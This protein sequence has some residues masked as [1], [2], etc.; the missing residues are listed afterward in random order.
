MPLHPTAEKFIT[1]ARAAGARPMCG[2]TADEARRVSKQMFASA[3]PGEPVREG[4]GHHASR[5]RSGD[6]PARVYTPS[7]EGPFPILV[8]LHGGG[9][10][11]GD[12][13]S[14]GRRLP[15]DSQRRGCIVVSVD[16][17]LAPEH[18]FPAPAE[19]AYRATRWIAE[20]AASWE[21]TAGRSRSGGVSAGG[22]LAAVVALMARDRGGPAL[23]C[24]VLNGAGHRLRLR[25][26]VAY[27][28]TAR[29][30]VLTR[31]EM[32]YFWEHYL[33]SP[34]DGDHPYASPLRAPDL[35]GLPPA[36]RADGRV[37]PVAR[38]RPGLCRRLEAAGVPVSYQCYEGMIHMVQG[39]EAVATWRAFLKEAFASQQPP[40]GGDLGMFELRDVTPRVQAPSPALQ[41]RRAGARRRARA[42]THRLLP[43]EPTTSS[44]SCG[45]PRLSPRSSPR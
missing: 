4:R 22:N 15:G 16:Y 14:S 34:E 20:N 38:R 24:Q 25:H 7:G 45:A 35:S 2:L 9:W 5:V 18:K 11:V 10:V 23:A 12:L 43:G 40:N 33:R 32:Q 30:I 6:I 44:R 21:A 39:P 37:R 26:P 28:S 41:G 31:D 42:D 19:D 8:Y 17:R 36:L 1:L 3:P 27:R 13:D 29:T